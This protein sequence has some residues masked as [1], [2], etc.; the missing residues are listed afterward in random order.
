MHNQDIRKQPGLNIH[1]SPS[2]EVVAI[3]S[4]EA[5]QVWA[6]VE[7]RLARILDGADPVGF[8]SED[9]LTQIQRQNMQLWMVPGYAACV[10]TINIYPQYKVALVCFLAGDEMDRWFGSLMDTI[11]EWARQ[12]GCKFIEQ[13]G[14]DGWL[15]V[16]AKR[17]WKKLNT[18]M[19]KTL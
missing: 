4:S 8:S 15:K 17:G 3:P 16:G 13:H 2:L 6:E 5:V 1:S 19:R 18:T 9:V 12:M 10:T 14:R 7:P 11:E